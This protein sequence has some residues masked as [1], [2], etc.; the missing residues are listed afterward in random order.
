MYVFACTKNEYV[1]GLPNYHTLKSP[2]TF[3]HLSHSPARGLYE[4]Q[5]QHV[6]RFPMVE[7]V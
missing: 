4:L 7:L 2:C 1:E 6:A 3:R 5:E